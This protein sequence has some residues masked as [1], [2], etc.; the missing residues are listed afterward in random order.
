MADLSAFPIAKRWPAK[1]PNILQLYSFPT[2]NG[3]KASIA[4]EEMGLP[5]EAHKV[6]LADED[7]KSPEF[8]SLNPNNK[9]PAIIDPNG[10]DGAPIGL[11]ESGAIL[12]YLA[13]KSGKLIGDSATER[14]HIIQWLMFQM[15][16]LGPML[17]QLGFFYKFAG[18]Q[19]GDDRPKQRYIDEAKRLLKVLNLELAGKDWIA[20]ANYSI[21]DIAIA[22]WLGALEFYGA[23]EAVGWEDNGN[24]V[25]YLDRFLERPAV[26]VGRNT[27]PR[28]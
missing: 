8:L 13:D 10:P 23:K 12:I 18:S 24:L 17:G 5:Y 6:T 26:Q 25:A 9:I 21:A 28:G 11:F 1:N 19:W 22:P 15:G 20:G 16:G 2:P 4:L 14:A 3:V 7:V 27:P